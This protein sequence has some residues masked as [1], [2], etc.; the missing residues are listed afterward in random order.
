MNFGGS[1]P[2]PTGCSRGCVLRPALLPHRASRLVFTQVTQ[3]KL[4]ASLTVRR[5]RLRSFRQSLRDSQGRA[6]MTA[7]SSPAHFEARS[8]ARPSG[9]QAHARGPQLPQSL[10]GERIAADGSRGRV[11]LLPALTRTLL[12]VPLYFVGRARRA[13]PRRLP[14]V[15]QEILP[16]W[17]HVAQTGGPRGLSLHAERELQ[18]RGARLCDLGQV[19]FSLRTLL[20]ADI[21]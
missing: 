15:T 17:V 12:P 6:V 1:G 2:Q 9:C 20:F 5:L 8:R 18:L 16:V 3:G 19:T 4:L 14:V 11:R 13:R 10:P 7:R 21:S